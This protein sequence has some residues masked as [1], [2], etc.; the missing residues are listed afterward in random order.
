M[1]MYIHNAAGIDWPTA[2]NAAT[3]M[4]M[5]PG[6]ATRKRRRRRGSDDTAE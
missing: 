4:A 3:G 6:L 5:L 2:A 1:F